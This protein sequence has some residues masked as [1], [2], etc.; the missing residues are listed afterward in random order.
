M[1]VPGINCL[2]GLLC[3]VSLF[4]QKTPPPKTLTGELNREIPSWLTLGGE[5]RMRVESFHG[6]SFRD[7]GDTYLLNRLRLNLG[8]KAT[9][10][11]RFQFEAQ[12]SRVFGQNARPAPAS[13]RDPMDLRLG[14]VEFGYTEGWAQMRAGRQAW[15]FGEGRLLAD[16]NWSNVGR[17]FDGA[18]LTL[19][20]G[21]RKV[22]L[23]GGITVKPDGNQFDRT[24]PG[25]HFYGAYG[26]LGKLIKD[27]T[28]EPYFLWRLE[29]DMK[30]ERGILGHWNGRTMGFRWVGKLPYG[31]D[32]GGELAGQVGSYAGDTIRALAGHW[33]IGHTL[34]DAKHRPRFYTE[35]NHASGDGNPRDGRHGGFDPLFPSTHDKLGIA[36]LFTW[37]NLY[38]SRSGIEYTLSPRW[39]LGAAYNSYW[40]QNA[41]DG[42]YVAGKMIARSADGSAGRHIGQQG[43]VQAT[44]APTRTTQ[45]NGGY[46][47]FFPGGFLD[48]TTSHVPYHIVFCNIAQ[49][50]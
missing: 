33:V 41:R 27:A 26:S 32:Y 25:E 14:Y 34:A 20:H 17:S 18:K 4:A 7:L 16:P 13:Q 9:P 47:H 36:D 48:R 40:L 2:T 42:V 46:G 29:H 45:I 19:Q 23:F 6:S 39:K 10:W 24:T 49:R 44:Y 35:W 1:K 50:F 5:E 38:H 43:D 22:D 28:I 3:T 31:L 21:T 12:D 30:N 8:V 11:M 37:I 15:V